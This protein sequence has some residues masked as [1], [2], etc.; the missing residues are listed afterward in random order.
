MKLKLVILGLLFSASVFS[1]SGKEIIKNSI[2]EIYQNKNIKAIDTWYS[3]DFQD[4][5][6]LPGMDTGIDGL[7]MSAQM[8]I[9]AFS[10]VKF[11]IKDQISEGDKIVSRLVMTG[12]HSG[13]F[14][15]MPA[16][17]K[18]VNV[19]GIRIDYVKNGKIVEYWSNFDMAGLMQ[20]LKQ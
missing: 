20:Q 12:T 5:S 3:A 7:R 1:Q 16:T 9:S 15:G 19:T 17:N 11:N 10:N 4:H 14:M 13:N 18:S 8:F 6:A 2:V